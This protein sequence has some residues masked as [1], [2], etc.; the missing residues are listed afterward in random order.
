MLSV[1]SLKSGAGCCYIVAGIYTALGNKDQ[2]FHWLE[3]GYAEREDFMAMLKV[4]PLVDELRRDVRF[5]S[6]LERLGFGN[7]ANRETNEA[8]SNGRPV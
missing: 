4:D 5:V 8:A 6:L 7:A 2:A 3:R 1:R